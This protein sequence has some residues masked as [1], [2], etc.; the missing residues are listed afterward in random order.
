MFRNAAIKVKDPSMLML[1]RTHKETVFKAALYIFD[2]VRQNC[3]CDFPF[4]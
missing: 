3:N 1:L 4:G 2:L